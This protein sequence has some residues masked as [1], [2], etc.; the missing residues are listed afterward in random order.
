MAESR[1]ADCRRTRSGHRAGGGA[2]PRKNNA[3]RGIAAGHEASEDAS[4]VPAPV[5]AGRSGL[6]KVLLWFKQPHSATLRGRT[7][8]LISTERVEEIDVERVQEM[9]LEPE[10]IG[11][12]LSLTLS[13][14]R[15]VAL[16]GIDPAK[17]ETLRRAVIDAGLT[18]LADRTDEPA[19]RNAEAVIA[20][21]ARGEN[22]L[23]R[24]DVEE[25]LAKTRH[26]GIPTEWPTCW[27]GPGLTRR[28]RDVRRFSERDS[29]RIRYD[30]N[31]AFIERHGAEIGAAAVAAERARLTRAAEDGRL[32]AAEAAVKALTSTGRTV[33]RTDAQKTLDAIRAAGL[34][35]EWPPEADD[36]PAADR[37][38]R[39][40][41]F[42]ERTAEEITAEIN[43]ELIT[44]HGS[45]L[46][47]KAVARERARLDE[48]GIRARLKDAERAMADVLDGPVISQP[49]AVDALRSRIADAGLPGQ[50]AAETDGIPVARRLRR[51]LRV[52]GTDAETILR[53]ANDAFVRK[54]ADEMAR[55]A[56]AAQRI[57]LNDAAPADAVET[58]E[59]AIEKAENAERYL[60][61]DDLQILRRTAAAPG[62][63][64]EWP[65]ELNRQKL[66]KR[67]KRIRDFLDEEAGEQRRRLNTEFVE[68]SAA[69]LTSEALD[70]Q[71]ALLARRTDAA[72]LNRLEEMIGEVS[73]PRRYLGGRRMK[74]IRRAVEQAGL[75]TEWA[76][77][78]GEDE[79]PRR[80]AALQA[81]G[82]ADAEDLRDD[83]N[84]RFLARELDERRELLDSVEKTPLSAEQ[85]EAVCRDDDR[86]LVVAGAGSGKSSVMVAKAALIAER[87]D[88]HHDEILMV[89]YAENAKT[90]LRQRIAARLGERAAELIDIKTFHGLGLSIIGN[91]EEERP[92]VAAWAADLVAR[93]ALIENAARVAARDPVHGPAL[94]RWLAYG[95]PP[96]DPPP[97]NSMEEYM[98]YI[99]ARELRTLQGELVKSYEELAIA[100]F[101]FVQQVPYRYE[102]PYRRRTA[103]PSRRQYAPDFHLTGTDIYIEHFAINADGRTPPF[104]D[105][106]E[107]LE[108]RRWKKK[109]HEANGTTLIET[110]SH[111]HDGRLTDRLRT[112]LAAHG[113][114]M[115]ERPPN[116][117]F[118]ILN[119]KR[120]VSAFVKLAANFLTHAKG[121]N[122]SISEIADKVADEGRRRA[123]DFAK[124]VEPIHSAIE[125]DLKERGEIDF[126]DMINKA[127]VHVEDGRWRSP[128]KYVLVDEFQDISQGRAKL[129][130]ALLENRRGA[131]LFAVG[132]DW[133]SIFRF[134]GAD[135][136]L[137]THFERHFGEVTIT[138]LATTFRCRDGLTAVADEFIS[139]NP[140]Q[141]R[142][143]T[144][145]VAEL[146][147]PGVKVGLGGS[148]AGR[149]LDRALAE[150][151]AENPADG[152]RPSV[153]L[154]ARY[155]KGRPKLEPLRK[156]HPG[157]RLATRTVHAAKGLEAEYCVI[158]G[159]KGGA[160]GF[161]SEI[162]DDPIL[163]AVRSEPETYP[164][165][166]ERRLFYVALTRAKRRAYVIEDAGPPSIF[167]EELLQSATGRV[168]AFGEERGKRGRGGRRPEPGIS[169]AR[170][171]HTAGGPNSRVRSAER[172][173]RGGP[174]T[175]WRARNA[176]PSNRRVRSRAAMDG[177]T[178]GRA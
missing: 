88:A 159:M 171:I 66:P 143:T 59:S 45:E 91:A 5:E 83:C 146:P 157:L 32:A 37:L 52:L 3:A 135:V 166:E 43:D 106:D 136:S 73:R 152:E 167:V 148:D 177:S 137:M 75:P 124:A 74:E 158:V 12:E 35:T 139:K 49:R 7:I 42:A 129:L 161:P 105:E 114:R 53:E 4:G 78:I 18:T 13:D 62:L 20:Y 50:W 14:G 71:R 119:E 21:A 156:A 87:G 150:I 149:L 10:C 154:L 55:D 99:R 170:T 138:R 2:P 147:G 102:A 77:E 134:A 169:G 115:E 130:R 44:R 28:L 29:D 19:L 23:Q 84:R 175:E 160:Y 120:Y 104:I 107:Y 116:R 133:Q 56:I 11:C 125:A 6:G 153:L 70:G 110:F 72:V 41:T 101:L 174:G 79:L 162:E 9:R 82:A 22:F 123:A 94:T 40:A 86:N 132:D 57:R 173:G 8:E 145:A 118:D 163:D 47:E 81:F 164:H 31:S 36:H 126:E 168:E 121:A 85:R 165:A 51:V 131:R 142:K 151:E 144:R 127:V 39:A 172:V 25:I 140:D 26:A 1:T 48:P 109:F 67:L 17:A 46:A 38:R 27:D 80:L 176:E 93:N 111:E 122:L 97:L 112:K 69:E 33:Q 100:N 103:T 89:A 76:A 34:P 24:R 16:H 61:E 90:E 68:R 15:M 58:A 92:S 117:L 96:P 54:H 63:P 65:A 108:G 95:G 60:Q 128:Y 113:I 64:R 155:K 98:E 141:L 178:E 30:A